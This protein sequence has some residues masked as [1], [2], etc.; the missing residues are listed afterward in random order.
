VNLIHVV[1]SIRRGPYWGKTKAR[2]AT[3]LPGLANTRVNNNIGLARAA[4]YG[5][6]HAHDNTTKFKVSLSDIQ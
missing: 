6:H 1:V 5:Y 3:A 2:T 4:N